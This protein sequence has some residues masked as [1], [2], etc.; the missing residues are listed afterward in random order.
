MPEFLS[1]FIDPATILAWVINLAQA[2]ATLFVGNTVAGWAKRLTTNSLQAAKL[3]VALS[4][5]LGSIARYIVLFTTLIAAAGTLGFDT[6]SLTAILAS[7]GLAV[8]LALQGTLSSFA[9]GVLILWFRPFTIGDVVS[10]AGHSGKVTEIGL[11]A[12]SLALLD[13]TTVVV[14]NSAVTGDVIQNHMHNGRKRGTVNIGVAY[15]SDLDHVR[16]TLTKAVSSV[17][18]IIED[19]FVVA[20]VSFGDSSLDWV[21]HGHCAPADYLAMVEAMN[22]AIYNELNAAKIDIPYPNLVL[23]KSEG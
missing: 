7:A 12:T 8:G 10:I 6:T 14:P 4:Q 13:N 11:F 19:D 22:C 18:Q 5:F 23:H 16:A 17:P 2:G 1:S 20:F 15:G 3:D 21:V 9:S